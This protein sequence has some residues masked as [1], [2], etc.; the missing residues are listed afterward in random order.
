MRVA[1][2]GAG[3]SGRWTRAVTGLAV[4]V[5]ALTAV[6]A[7]PGG[8]GPAGAAPLSQSDLSWV[9]A[10]YWDVLE[11]PP[12]TAQQGLRA[13]QLADGRSRRSIADEL[14]R[15]AEHAGV[16]V[17]RT[18]ARVL[19]RAPDAPSRS[20]WIDRLRTGERPTTVA[21]FLYG[22]AELF[23][24]YG[25]TAEAYVTFLYRD[26]LG[27]EPDPAGAAYWAGRIEAGDNRT[28]L[29]RHWLLSAEA[30][31][32]RAVLLFLDVLG[33]QPT[34][35]EQG[36][37]GGRLQRLDERQVRAAV[38]SGGEHYDRAARPWA[39][40][41]L[42]R[43]ND[44]SSDPAISASGR[45][46]AFAS[47]ADNLTPGGSPVGSDIFVLD[48]RTGRTRAI[49]AGN[50]ASTNPFVSADG[51]TVVFQSDA[52]DLVAGDT[53]GRTDVFRASTRGGGPIERLTDGD[54]PSTDPRTSDDGGIVV[55]TSTASD[56]LSVPDL[57]GGRPDVFIHTDGD[58]A[59]LERLP[60]AGGDT[61][62]PDVS[63]DGTKLAYQS[64][65]LDEEEPPQAYLVDLPL[66]PVP[67][68]LK[69]SIEEGRT[70]TVST[71]G[72]RLAYTERSSDPEVGTQV[73]FLDL[74]GT[75]IAH[76]IELG[77]GT[78]PLPRI[79]D[80]GNAVLLRRVFPAGSAPVPPLDTLVRA[81]SFSSVGR[82]G[83]QDSDLRADGRLVVATLPVRPGITHIEM[84]D[85]NLLAAYGQ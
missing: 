51:L 66:A 84:F 79:S 52:T 9:Y 76:R 7:A 63:A 38:V 24:R 27:R 8:T 75:T 70:P 39:S 17:D 48:R 85:T 35:A 45:I 18:Y 54:A 42:D 58:P 3:A 23:Q 50:G 21:S 22:S 44:D 82:F 81:G 11:R 80:G 57:D 2:N 34:A 65:T 20:Y 56:L 68:P 37:W 77:A 53:N 36:D 32:L 40:T 60:G 10:A 43:G 6:T 46:V 78:D 15:S 62:A 49:T 59:T 29:A 73:H 12:T 64:S 55:F 71:S 1:T 69:V 83:L 41:R 72:H 19:G 4:A 47:T 26:V 25:G 74:E 28:G 13:E 67:T 5:V 30:S 33:R 31:G 61:L 14:V 16:I